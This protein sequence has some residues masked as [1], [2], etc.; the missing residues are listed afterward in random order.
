M[1]HGLILDEWARCGHIKQII[2]A[3]EKIQNKTQKKTLAFI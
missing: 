2:A 1:V 3:W